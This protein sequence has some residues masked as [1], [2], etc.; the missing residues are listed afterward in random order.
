MRSKYPVHAIVLQNPAQIRSKK[1]AHFLH[2][3]WYKREYSDDH[4]SPMYFYTN[5][6]N[7]TN[8]NNRII[9]HQP[10]CKHHSKIPPHVPLLCIQSH[11][12]IHTKIHPYALLHKVLQ[13]S[14][15]YYFYYIFYIHITSTCKHILSHHSQKII[16]L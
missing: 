14:P 2:I 4:I 6:F 15:P 5:T 11:T 1:T 16:N 9:V 8:K 7:F 12:T 10:R 13:E 3:Y